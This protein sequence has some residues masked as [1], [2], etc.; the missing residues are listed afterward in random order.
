MSWLPVVNAAEA[1]ILTAEFGAVEGIH[2]R[3]WPQA[4]AV[5]LHPSVLARCT[6]PF[7]VSR[8]L[9]R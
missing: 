4:P 3:L 8:E 2:Y 1:A 9:A 7:H 6:H 5:E